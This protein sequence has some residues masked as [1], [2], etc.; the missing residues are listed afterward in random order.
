MCHGVFHTYPH[1]HTVIIK[2]LGSEF[3]SITKTYSLEMSS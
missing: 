2:R 3:T 1:G